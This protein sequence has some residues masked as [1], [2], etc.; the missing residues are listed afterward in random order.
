MTVGAGVG[1]RVGVTVAV[2]VAVTVG[3]GVG[4]HVGVTVAVR[5]AVTVGAGVGVHVGV[6]VAV[7]VAVG[8]TIPGERTEV[9][10]GV[11]AGGG[12]AGEPGVGTAFRRKTSLPTTRVE[13]SP[14]WTWISAITRTTFAGT[15]VSRPSAPR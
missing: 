12:G 6:T 11:V 9:G 4:V 13:V 7:R 5:V 2:R 14:R 3:T 10:G 15:I 1:V 8:V